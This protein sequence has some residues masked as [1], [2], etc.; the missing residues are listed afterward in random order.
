ME[1]NPKALTKHSSENFDLKRTKWSQV[2]FFEG[3]ARGVRGVVC[4][5]MVMISGGVCHAQ[6]VHRSFQAGL[7]P[8]YDLGDRA[9]SDIFAPTDM[10]VTNFQTTDKLRQEA[11]QKVPALFRYDSGAAT[12]AEMNLRESFAY[13]KLRFSESLLI[14][15]KRPRLSPPTLQ[16][17]SYKDFIKWFQTQ[18]PGFPL[19]S[20]LA[21]LWA[22]QEPDDELLTAWVEYLRQAM[23]QC[24]HSDQLPPEMGF[25]PDYVRIV[26][27]SDAKELISAQMVVNQS[28]NVMRSNM[29]TLA[30]ARAKLLEQVGYAQ[31]SLGKF[32]AG[33]VV[34][35]CFPEED[36]TRQLREDQVA[37]IWA[38]DRFEKGE[39]IAGQGQLITP[40]VKAALDALRSENLALAHSNRMMAPVAGASRASNWRVAARWRL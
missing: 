9:L 1:R 12:E 25:G 33:F 38:V 40:R 39:L 8:S 19:T 26:P 35:N 31:D 34:E 4:L 11:S 2:V 36:L 17:S 20:E 23:N 14:A 7:V 3:I 6:G 21:R 13:A 10:A 5:C 28:V 30:A 18:H 29:V 22:L 15:A 24:L 37:D 32:L 27:V 16:H